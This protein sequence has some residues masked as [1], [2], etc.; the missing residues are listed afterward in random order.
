MRSRGLDCGLGCGQARTVSLVALGLGSWYC[1]WSWSQSWSGIGLGI[2]WVL[3]MNVYIQMNVLA[4]EPV[5]T[6]LFVCVSFSP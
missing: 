6:Y 1:S 2:G 3:Q 5:F 4:T